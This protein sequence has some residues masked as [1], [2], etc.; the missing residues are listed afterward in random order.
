M[1]ILVQLS[2]PPYAQQMAKKGAKKGD[3]PWGEAIQYWFKEKHLRQAHVVEGTGMSPNKASRAAN[4]LDVRMDT[5]RQFAEFFEVPIE[6]VLVSP[7]RRLSPADDRHAAEK[8]AETVR[9]VMDQS[10][11]TPP[12]RHIDPRML[13]LARR[14]E[15]LPAKYQKSAIELIADYERA[16]KKERGGGG[17]RGRS[18][19]KK[20]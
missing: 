10:R 20:T 1:A 6:S 8:L 12:V 19:P 17:G 14:I 4:G 18:G 3:G 11:P 16:A 5:L 7:L 15:K 2:P 13:A 9:R